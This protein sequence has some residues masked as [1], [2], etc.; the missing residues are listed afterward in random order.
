MRMFKRK[1]SREHIICTIQPYVKNQTMENLINFLNILRKKRNFDVNSYVDTKTD[2][3]NKFFKENGLDSAVIGISGGVDSAVVYSLLDHASKKKDSPIKKIVGLI[4]PI[5]CSGTTNQMEAMNKARNFCKNKIMENHSTKCEFHTCD[6]TEA[7]EAFINRSMYLDKPWSNGQLASIVRTPCL[8]HHAAL[9]QENGFNS[10]VVG[11][12]NRDEGSYIGFFGK[13]SDAMVDLQ[14]IADIHKSEVY[15]VAKLLGVTK[16]IIEAKPTGDV[17]D[18]RVDEEM[19]G[20]PYWF[21]ELYL[22]LKQFR[23]DPLIVKSLI[24]QKLMWHIDGEKIELN[25]S[26]TN[27]FKNYSMAIEEIHN[28]N[29]H[30]YKVGSPAHFIDVMDRKIEGGWQ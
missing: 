17:H 11:T 16:E 8:Y 6:L 19:I 5:R 30:K 23:K 24:E 13:A 26:Q 18:G 14:P 9:L 29:S 27:L 25:I 1:Q 28:K 12:T 3:I 4:M 21:L 2:I 22:L 20:A 10:I 7:Y 15:Q